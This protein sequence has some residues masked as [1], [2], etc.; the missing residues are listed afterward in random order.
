MSGRLMV[1]GGEFGRGQPEFP[2]RHRKNFER[3]AKKPLHQLAPAEKSKQHQ[4]TKVPL[5]RGIEFRN[6]TFVSSIQCDQSRQIAGLTLRTQ[7][8]VEK[9]RIQ[10]ELVLVLRL[11]GKEF[12]P[13]AGDAV[14]VGH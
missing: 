6:L 7:A 10:I 9:L 11:P 14:E 12:L 3:A 13:L 2:R 1:S 4:P 8:D 5:D